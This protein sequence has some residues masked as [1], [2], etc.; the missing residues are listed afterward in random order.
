MAD[1]QTPKQT[2]TLTNGITIG[3][4]AALLVVGLL[5]ALSLN[6]IYAQQ[7]SY[8]TKYDIQVNTYAYG[9]ENTFFLISIGVIIAL[10]GIYLLVFGCLNHF[11]PK[12]REAFAIRNSV[13]TMGN[14]LI[15]FG[16]GSAA[17]LS[18]NL[19]RQFYRPVTSTWS[20]LFLIVCIIGGLIAVTLGAFLIRREYMYS[21]I[22]TKV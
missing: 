2:T 19:I 3:A 15:N 12:V 10:L 18:A 9:F 11:N 21:Q 20:I 16:F 6:S 13:T 5:I 7:I 4:G 14:F 17:L 8:L 1:N 22:V